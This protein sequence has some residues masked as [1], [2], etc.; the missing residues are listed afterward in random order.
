LNGELLTPDDNR[1]GAPV[2]WI[3]LPS[4][5]TKLG[6]RTTFGDNVGNMYETGRSTWAGRTTAKADLL[7][8]SNRSEGLLYSDSCH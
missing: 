1:D 7:S 5:T 6:V 3:P 2:A 8:V 4:L